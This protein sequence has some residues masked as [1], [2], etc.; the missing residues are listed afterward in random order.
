MASARL[1]LFRLKTRDRGYRKEYCPRTKKGERT[2]RIRSKTILSMAI[3]AG[4]AWALVHYTVSPLLMRGFLLIEEHEITRDALRAKPALDDAIQSLKVKTTDWASWDDTY[5]F[6]ESRDPAY[7]ESNLT[8]ESIAGLQVNLIAFF[9]A[10]GNLLIARAVDLATGNYQEAPNDILSYF[11]PGSPFLAHDASL[12]GYSGMLRANTQPF[13]F[14]TLPVLTSSSEGPGRGTVLFAAYVGEAHIKRLSLLSQLDLRLYQLDKLSL[15]QELLDHAEEAQKGGGLFL[16]RAHPEL[17]LAYQVLPDATGA[18][19]ILVEI[20][21]SR[22]VYQQALHTRNSLSLAL[23]ICG[24]GLGLALLLMLEHSVLSRLAKMSA[25]VT[26]I[27]SSDDLSARLPVTG[28]DEISAVNGAVNHMLTGLENSYERLLILKDA[29]ESANTAKGEFLA[30]MSHEIRTPMNGVLG[31]SE[32]LAETNLDAEQREF[33][34]MIHQSAGSLV[35][36]INDILDFSKIDSGKLDLAPIPFSL[37]ELVANETGLFCFPAMERGIEFVTRIDEVIPDTFLGD[38]LRIGQ[39]LK[40]LIGNA[41]K[42]TPEQGGVLVIVSADAHSEESVTLHFTV[43][44]SGIGIADHKQNHIFEA[45][46]QADSS[47]T[48]EFG[49]TGLGLAI[50]KRLVTLMRGRIWVE[51]KVGVG[52]AFHFTVT[53]PRVATQTDK[54]EAEAPAASISNRE[55]FHSS[56]PVLLVEDNLVNQHLMKKLLSQRGLSIV[57]A[58]NGREAVRQIQEQAFSLV[59]MDCQMPEMDGYEATR[60]IRQTMQGSTIPIIALTANALQ[61]DREKCLAHGMNDYL[62]KPLKRDELFAKVEKYLALD[63]LPA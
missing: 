40:N 60:R 45:F 44:D 19:A 6:I 37:R 42:F 29:A 15:P 21:A 13:I 14:A 31:M 38:S 32:L 43:S 33:V 4:L 41:L 27:T 48:R 12:E 18:P 35:S 55:T 22:A 5:E 53:L 3:V 34:M 8:A 52:S 30:N 36:L 1:L 7:V 56:L 63:K 39:V 26:R 49:G 46:T 47:T 17:L 23:A 25:V 62:S 20:N 51:S 28:N 10:K 11:T 16:D 59:L 58:S 61:G 24:A 57:V 54:V 2:L 50:V 9:D